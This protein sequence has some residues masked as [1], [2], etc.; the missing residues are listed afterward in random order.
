MK[1]IEKA[2]VQL[3][4]WD[5]PHLSRR[6]NEVGQGSDWIASWADFMGSIEY[7]RFFQSGQFIY[8]G[9]VREST[10]SEWT[11]RLRDWAKSHLRHLKDIDW[12]TVPG[13]ISMVNLLYGFTEY[14]EFA[15]RLAQAGVY[16]D[17]VLVRIELHGAKGFMLTTELSRLW[18]EYCVSHENDLTH[19]WTLPSEEL[20]ANSAEHSLAA[21]GWFF[22][23]F[24]WMNPNLDGLR[25]EQQKFLRKN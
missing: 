19:T 1:V 5:F 20:I 25:R 22:E 6:E 24:G 23:S 12:N 2:K 14:F 9:A 16:K 3:R 17:K 11:A 13:Y 18:R 8:F 10:E 7:W 21:A 15:A 4:G